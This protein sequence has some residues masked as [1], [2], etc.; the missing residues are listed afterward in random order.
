MDK[1]FNCPPI[2]FLIFN[3]PDL[4]RRVFNRIR[5]AQ[6][7]T[8]FISADGPRK[9]HPNDPLLCLKA[10]E[11]IYDV[12]WECDV[13]TL[14][15]DKNLGCRNAVSNAISWFFTFIDKGIILEDDCLPDFSFFEYCE[16][17]LYRYEFDERIGII[18]GNNFINPPNFENSYYFTNFPHM[19]GWAS[20]KRIWEN[21]DIGI[22]E[23]PQ[24]RSTSFLQFNIGSKKY[25]KNWEEIFDRTHGNKIDT[26]DYQLVFN[27]W[28][29]NQLSIAPKF[30]LVSN[31]GFGTQSTHT[32]DT[33]SEFAN[34][35]ISKL[36]FPL[37]HPKKVERNLAFDYK[38][39]K[40]QFRSQSKII[41]LLKK[42]K[43][44]SFY[45]F[46]RK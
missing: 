46:N 32:F 38:E 37:I 25:I 8:L 3:R 9:D 35:P 28:K 18:S 40:I 19:W 24:L 34:L 29:H 17:L 31:I 23:W 6:P 10:R 43:K 39:L 5:E 15:H 22:S 42:I 41:S 45:L 20:W 21:Y 30:N 44:K 16:E 11:I 12:D 13:K 26:W 14:F 4:T 7:R 27:L 36:V 33:D 1:S 2:L